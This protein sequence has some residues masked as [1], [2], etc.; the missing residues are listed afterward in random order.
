M[1][2]V[3]MDDLIRR[4]MLEKYSSRKMIK[5]NE[6]DTYYKAIQGGGNDFAVKDNGNWVEVV[7]NGLN[8][9]N[10]SFFNNPRY[11]YS[12]IKERLCRLAW[13]IECDD[14]DTLSG[15]NSYGNIDLGLFTVQN[16]ETG[17]TDSYRRAARNIANADNFLGY[18]SVEFVPGELFAGVTGA[19]YFG[20]NIG[21]RSDIAGLTIRITQLDFEIIK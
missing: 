18:H 17:I 4:A 14:M 13:T 21:F 16:Q 10:T 20:W 6:F 11:E 7:S 1:E 2:C 12:D 15:T 8:L 3:L 9:N 5:H 19:E